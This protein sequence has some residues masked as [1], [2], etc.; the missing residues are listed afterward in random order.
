MLNTNDF[1]FNNVASRYFGMNRPCFAAAK[2][3]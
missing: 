1:E 2:L 3:T